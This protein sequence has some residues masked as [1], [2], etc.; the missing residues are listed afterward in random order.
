VSGTITVV[1]A[2][3]AGLGAVRA[4][5]AQGYSGRVVLVGQEQHAPYDRPPLSK[6]FLAGSMPFGA[7]SLAA[8]Q[9]QE[10]DVDVRA[11]ARAVA[12]HATEREVELASGERVG[13]DGVVLATGAR[14]RTLP[15]VETAHRR[16]A[17]VHTLRTVEDAIALR[18]VLVPGARLVVVGAG[19]I[20][21]EVASTARALG[22]EVTVLEVAPVPLEAALGAQ[23]G[24]VCGALHAA[25]GV[26]LLTGL[27][28]ERLLEDEAG[29]VRAIRTADGRQLQADAVL[30]A[31]GPVPNVEWLSGSG[32]QLDGG[33][34]TDAVGATG[35]QGVVATGDCARRFDPATGRHERQEHWT[36]ALQH[37]QV[38]V[39]ALLGGPPPTLPATAVLPYF[40]S[41]Q[42]GKR[43]QFAGH[44]LP[45]DAV[46]VVE[47][48]V[49]DY[50]F[51][52]VY[53]REGAAVAVL[54]MNNP[55]VFGRWRREL[56]AALPVPAP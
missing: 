25:H 55:R 52:A 37:P 4:L 5:R 6:E 43:L 50:S 2:G 20:G 49:A 41:D 38:A 26:Q 39:S 30:V 23:M 28:V 17:G 46:E 1:G 45:G 40:W 27:G 32:L 13:G 22:V 44:R 56:A 16:M 33:V 8:P 51:V 47:G 10:L 15:T 11:G 53:R 7:L 19:F 18:E 31:I 35:I 12:L 24:A 3:L 34:H 29:R 14:A 42:Y 9:D 54:S 36:N 21:A 48:S